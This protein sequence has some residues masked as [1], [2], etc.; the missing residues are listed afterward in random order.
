MA[1]HDLLSHFMQGMFN[2]ARYDFV[3]GIRTWKR[4]GN[5]PGQGGL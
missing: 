4:P 5:A 1:G 3:A 2:R